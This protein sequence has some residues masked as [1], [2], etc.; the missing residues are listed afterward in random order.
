M[1]WIKCVKTKVSYKLHP[2]TKVTYMVKPRSENAI[3][4]FSSTTS[5]SAHIQI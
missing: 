2:V 1:K 5:L 3:F 4:C